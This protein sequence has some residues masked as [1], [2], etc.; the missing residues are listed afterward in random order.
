MRRVEFTENDD[1]ELRHS[2]RLAARLLLAV[3]LMQL[4]LILAGLALFFLGRSFVTA[5]QSRTGVEPVEARREP[6][7]LRLA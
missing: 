5:S 2:Q 3:L 7:F 4:L 1:V 6:I